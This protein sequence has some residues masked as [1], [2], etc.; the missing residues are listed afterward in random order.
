MHSTIQHP[1]ENQTARQHEQE[2]DI[3]QP[4]FAS[5]APTQQTADAGRS[6]LATLRALVPNR[7][8]T[9]TESLRIAELQAARL[10]TILN[11]GDEDL[12]EDAIVGL[13][14]IRIVRRR[15]PTSGV[16]YWDGQAWVIALNILEPDTR[17]HFT[18]MHEYKHILDHG[19]VERLYTGTTTTSAQQQAEHAADYFAGCALMPKKL[20][21]RAWGNR[22]QSPEALAGLFDVS[23]RAAE[24][25]LAQLGLTDAVPRCGT[26]T[27]SAARGPWRTRPYFRSLSTNPNWR[28]A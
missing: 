16:S 23:P 3:T 19:H 7:T 6:V 4:P 21:K 20:V 10:R 8:I 9:F 12:P 18:L 25:R 14:R 11:V 1:H 22:I 27:T 26:S 24:V 13:P 28:A 15:L 5:P 17:Q 2:P